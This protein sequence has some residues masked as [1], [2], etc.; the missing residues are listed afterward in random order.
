MEQHKAKKQPEAKEKKSDGS[1]K[2]KQWFKDK[3]I[4]GI[5]GGVTV[6][7]VI[8][9]VVVLCMN[10]KD[11]KVVD[12]TD[13]SIVEACSTAKSHGWNVSEPMEGV[14]G[15]QHIDCDNS[16]AVVGSYKYDGKEHIVEIKW[17]Y[18]ILTEEE[19]KG[20]TVSEI[21]E[22]ARKNHL[23]FEVG[24]Y[25][26]TI[27]AY[28]SA[29]SCDDNRVP[30]EVYQD[31]GRGKIRMGFAKS[32]AEKEKEAK[33]KASS[34]SS[35]N[36]SKNTYPLDKCKTGEKYSIS[37]NGHYVIGNDIPS[38]TYVKDAPKS[39]SIWFDL[40]KTQSDYDSGK[41]DIDNL[42]ILDDEKTVQLNNGNIVDNVVD[43]GDIICK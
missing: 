42:I 6:A 7:V 8:I 37:Q 40:F 23:E 43:G 31:S 25:G 34:S 39:R 26:M 27:G 2:N 17:K 11:Y 35:S 4:L 36:S 41:S 30:D 16:Y 5:I 10:Q 38:G 14:S 18:R 32:G 1:K 22:L 20:K 28:N 33:E 9:L 24:T 13:M 15:K 12:L 19:Y 29:E 21:C 3:K